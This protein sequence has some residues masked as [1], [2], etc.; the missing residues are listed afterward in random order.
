VCCWWCQ[1]AM[2]LSL[3]CCR[4]TQMLWSLVAPIQ[5]SMKQP[6]RSR[7]KESHGLQFNCESVCI[8]MYKWKYH[9]WCCSM[10]PNLPSEENK[11]L[12]NQPVYK[13]GIPKE[14][15]QDSK[16]QVSRGWGGLKSP[17]K[18]V[19]AKPLTCLQASM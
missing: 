17:K 14:F 10:H 9:C 16:Q 8:C 11:V 19:T 3:L 2:P 12:T 6:A 15:P 1:Q 7:S 18:T 4:V 5:E 13:P